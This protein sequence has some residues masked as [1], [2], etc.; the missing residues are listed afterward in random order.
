MSDA[1]L[2]AEY[3]AGSGEPGDPRADA[4]VVE[5]QARELAF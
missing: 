4:L 2:V 5:M 1:Q 3:L